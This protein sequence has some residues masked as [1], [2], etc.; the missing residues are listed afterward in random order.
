MDEGQSTPGTEMAETPRCGEV[1]ETP[2]AAEDDSASSMEGIEESGAVRQA[3]GAA[4][5]PAPST[6]SAS[7]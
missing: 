3:S 7:A 2:F 1:R 5:N 6:D 4:E